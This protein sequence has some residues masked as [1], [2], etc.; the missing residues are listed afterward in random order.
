MTDS[1]AKLPNLWLLIAAAASI[2]LITI[3]MRMTL[4]LFVLP[5]VNSTELSMTQFSLIIAVFQLMWGIS[6]PLSGALADRFGAFK[7]LAG[8]TVLLIAACLMVPQMP[9]YWG[10]IL[11]IGLLLAFGTG[12]GGFSII[13]GQ[14]AAK[15]P[16]HRRSLASGLVNAGGSAG[17]FLFAPLV[18]GLI[19]LPHVGWAGTFYV[20]AVIAILILPISW[21]LAGGKHASHTVHTDNGGQTLKQAVCKAFANRSYILLHLGFF[22]C[23]FHIA[24]LVTHLPTEISL[25][26]L[27]ATVASTSIAII[28]L[29]NIAGCIFSGWCTGRF[30]GKYVLFGLYASRVA[31]ILIYLAALKPI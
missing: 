29:A 5:V 28:G 4:G 17:Q 30:L 31:M 18:Q 22:T 12:S 3:G 8:G 19:A 9:T 1:S 7:V 20:W 14:V 21:W 25:C 10:L 26:G 23:G 16:P 15:T 13:M 2:L 6:Q 27:P 24:F 11:S